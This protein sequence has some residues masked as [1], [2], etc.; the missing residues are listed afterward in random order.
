MLDFGLA[1]ALEPTGAMSPGMSQAPTITT[2]AMTQA[3]MILGTAALFV[4]LVVV[5]P[6]IGL[7]TMVLILAGRHGTG[8]VG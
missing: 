5:I 6:D 1:K 4:C 3:G 2:P 8:S 7:Y